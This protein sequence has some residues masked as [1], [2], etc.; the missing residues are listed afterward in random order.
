MI[1]KNDIDDNNNNCYSSIFLTLTVCA[2]I[3]FLINAVTYST[4][5][6]IIDVL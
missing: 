4:N 2:T 3:N 5:T 6:A 1:N